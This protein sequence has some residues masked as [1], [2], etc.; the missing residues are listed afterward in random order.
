MTRPA[1]LSLGVAALLAGCA[2]GPNYHRPDAAGPV[3]F[4]E[5]WLPAQP[6]DDLPRGLWWKSYRDPLL[7]DLEASAEHSNQT[8]VR[9]EAAY[10]AALAAVT[11]SRAGLFPAVTANASSTKSY[12]GAGPS[13]AVAPVGSSTVTSRQDRVSVSA[14]WEIDLWGRL[15]RQLEASN[16]SAQASANDLA[17]ARLSIAA[18][19]AQDY[20][21]STCNATTSRA[22]CS[23]TDARSRSRRIATRPASRRAPT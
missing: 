18:N 17:A 23:A 15:R 4:K 16:S 7:D 14:D 2:V 12:S 22:T 10:R 6:G 5:A 11:G 21:P 19:L 3:A 20:A 9:A 8:L 13:G 1:P